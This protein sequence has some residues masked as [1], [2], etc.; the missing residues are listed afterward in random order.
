[1]SWMKEA[2]W[3]QKPEIGRIAIEG[4]RLAIFGSNSGFLGSV[5]QHYEPFEDEEAAI[6][7]AKEK[8]AEMGLPLHEEISRPR[9]TKMTATYGRSRRKKRNTKLSEPQS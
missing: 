4:K 1:M 3:D 7:A 5:I 9:I 2:Y 8:I 6:T